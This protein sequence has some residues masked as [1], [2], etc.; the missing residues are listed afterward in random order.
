MKEIWRDIKGYEGKY[1]IS[2]LGNVKSLHYKKSAS[3]NE[4]ILKT[5]C[6]KRHGKDMYKYVVLSKDNE[7]HTYYVHRLVAIYFVPNPNNKEYVNHKDGNKLN[8]DASNLEWVTPLENNLHAYHVLGKHPMRY[9]KFDKNKKSRKVAQYYISEQGHEYHIATYANAR[10][11]AI[12]NKL[13]QRSIAESCGGNSEYQ[14]V[15]GYIW[16]YED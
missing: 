12:I 5:R 4:R 6:C 2:N 14:Q 8:N 1:Q 7:T 13:N 16:K 11:A 3:M 9:Y 15:G 10:V